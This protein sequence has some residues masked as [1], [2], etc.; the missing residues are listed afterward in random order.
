MKAIYVLI[1]LAGLTIKA[2]A[3]NLNIEFESY[4]QQSKVGLVDEFF[5]RFNG[6]EGHPNIPVLDKNGHKDNLLMLLDLSRFK[7]QEDSLFILASKM[8]DK[9]IEDS[10]HIHYCDTSWF[11]IAHCKGELNMDDII[12]D[13]F[14]KVEHRG[15][16]MYK[17][18]ISSVNGDFLRTEPRNIN[19][20]IM[21]FPDDHETNFISLSRMTNEQP[22]NIGRFMAKNVSY[23][24]TSVFTYLVYSGQ[25]KISY[26][27]KLE[28]VFTQIP[29][30]VFHLEN[31]ERKTGNSGWL[32]TEIERC[33]LKREPIINPILGN[34]KDLA[35]QKLIPKSRNDTTTITFRAID[36]SRYSEEMLLISDYIRYMQ[37]EGIDLSGF[38]KCKMKELFTPNSNVILIDGEKN[39][40]DTLTITDFCD[41]VKKNKKSKLQIEAITVPV[42]DS[43]QCYIDNHSM[44]ESVSVA[45]YMIPVI[46]P[47]D[48]MVLLQKSQVLKLKV[49]NTEEGEELRTLLGDM[50]VYTNKRYKK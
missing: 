15:D 34:D 23:D 8:M 39:I 10:I 19:D 6:E 9:A 5:R 4:L 7:S 11:A 27:D 50:I 16:N 13:I 48:K 18:V 40:V 24:P 17:W 20:R 44:N 26:V 46:N 12:F 32:I 21:L 45:G 33:T 30:Y 29:G 31:I 1:F 3:Q 28:F 2:T 36:K 38:Y 22:F 41:Y 35:S 42:V 25:L 43:V 37:R 47:H 49:E 14:L